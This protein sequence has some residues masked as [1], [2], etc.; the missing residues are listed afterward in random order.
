MLDAADFGRNPHG[1]E[2]GEYGRCQ[3]RF[4]K[5]KK[6]SP[7]KRRGVLTVF[8]WTPDVL[9]TRLSAPTARSL[10]APQN[11]SHGDAHRSVPVPMGVVRGGRPCADQ[12][13]PRQPRT[14]TDQPVLLSQARARLSEEVLESHFR[15]V[16]S[17]SPVPVTPE[18]WWRALRLLAGRQPVR[19]P[20]LR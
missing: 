20:R 7:P 19:H 5:A 6:G 13:R 9:D 10:P 11:V 15:Q 4:R 17:P 18:A 1:S 14:R 2:F 16:L 12:Q 8:D 3:V